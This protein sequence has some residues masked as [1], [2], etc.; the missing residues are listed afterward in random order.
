MQALQDCNMR[1]DAL[2]VAMV[3]REI[4]AQEPEK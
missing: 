2:M 1:E 3:K 4:V